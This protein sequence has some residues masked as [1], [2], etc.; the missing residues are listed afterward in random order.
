MSNAVA[1]LSKVR[2]LQAAMSVRPQFDGFK[3]THKFADGMYSRSVWR[4][5]GVTVVGALHKHEHFTVVLSGEILVY[6]DGETK[7]CKAGDVFVTPSGTKRATHSL[8]DAE[9]MTV[10]R[11]PEKFAINCTEPTEADL[12]KIEAELIEPEEAPRLFDANNKLRNPALA[13]SQK[14]RRINK[15]PS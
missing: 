2:E 15:C 13:G 11:L 6:N 5:A 14:Q 9:L 7:H 12:D 10:H 4:P 1:K 8:T 3:T